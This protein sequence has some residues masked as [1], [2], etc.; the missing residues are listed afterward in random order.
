MAKANRKLS[1]AMLAKRTCDS[2]DTAVVELITR[3]QVPRSHNLASSEKTLAPALD[4]PCQV[5]SWKKT[6]N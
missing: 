3:V 5:H 1:Q 6:Q 2:S 4:W